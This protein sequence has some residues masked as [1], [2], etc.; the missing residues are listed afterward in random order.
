MEI[1][2]N[3]DTPT[4]VT[5]LEVMH[6][7]EELIESREKESGERKNN[8]EYA[9]L[10]HRDWIEDK[11]YEHLKSAPCANLSID[12][13]PELVSK[14]KGKK[15]GTGH[16]PPKNNNGDKNGG[17]KPADDGE[18]SFGLTDA[19]TLQILNL[20]PREPV[21][22]HLMIE[23]LH[24]RMT[25]ERQTALLKVIQSHATQEDGNDPMQLDD[26]GENV[27]GEPAIENGVM[28]D[29]EEFAVKEEPP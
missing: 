22:I 2:T 16:V 7:L 24:S 6:I 27:N 26:E 21:E 10:R 18:E 3:S 29:H 13:M 11:V 14:L 12:R 17:N 20:Q 4:L 19:E 5:N 28:H 25:E 9:K 1:L 15:V 8:K 23:E